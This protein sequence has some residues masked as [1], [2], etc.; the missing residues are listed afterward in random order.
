MPKEDRKE[1]K[2]E[3]RKEQKGENSKEKIREEN[4]IGFIWIILGIAAILLF[5]LL[6]SW[7]Y[8]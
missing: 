1:Q 4:R 6:S 7:V 2:G 3:D 8:K 5:W